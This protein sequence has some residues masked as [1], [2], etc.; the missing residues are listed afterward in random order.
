MS[1][2]KQLSTSKKSINLTSSGTSVPLSL[3]TFN[4]SVK[5]NMDGDDEED[6]SLE[7]YVIRFR[8]NNIHKSNYSD[9]SNLFDESPSKPIR[10]LITGSSS[11]MYCC[12][13][14]N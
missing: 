10:I 13:D 2:K 7:D 3:L 12:F 11:G 6:Q 9:P 5:S 1:D 8:G 4:F 14:R